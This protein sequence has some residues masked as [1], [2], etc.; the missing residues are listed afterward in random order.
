MHGSVP[1]QNCDLTA[2]IPS[3]GPTDACPRLGIQGCLLHGSVRGQNRDLITVISSFGPTDASPRG[4]NQGCC[5][6]AFAVRMVVS[7]RYFH[8][9]VPRVRLAGGGAIRVVA[10]ELSRLESR[11]TA[12]IPS[13]GPTDAFPRRGQP[14]VLRGSFRGQ[15][16]DLTGLLRGR[17]S[18]QNGALTA[19][20]PSSSP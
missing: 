17:L 12:V 13:F 2:V 6:S 7:L 10:Q 3:F 19:V 16:G 18:G 8:H 5:T 1:G 11:S 14:G 20:I 15:I 4:G 9:S